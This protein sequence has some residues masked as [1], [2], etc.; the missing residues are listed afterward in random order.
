[1]KF[2]KRG[3][4][5]LGLLALGIAAALPAALL[6]SGTSKARQAALRVHTDAPGI[7]GLADGR[8]GAGIWRTDN[9]LAPHPLWKQVSDGYLASNAIGSLVIDPT[10]P[11]GQTIYAGTGE[12]NG[13]SDS[14][15]G[16]GLYKSTNGGSTWQLLSGSQ[17]V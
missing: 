12:G 10:Q 8:E 2:R 17:S 11:N 14:E 6:S 3:A 1:M 4:L 9:A 5:A 7:G 15:A 16:V 13:S